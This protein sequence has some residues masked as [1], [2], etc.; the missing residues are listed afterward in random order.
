MPFAGH[1][2]HCD[3]LCGIGADGHGHG[4]YVIRVAADELRVL[5]LHPDQPAAVITGPS[6]PRWGHAAA[7]RNAD[8]HVAG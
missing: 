7:E 8:R 3:L 4:R 5:G 2:I 1:R 6:P